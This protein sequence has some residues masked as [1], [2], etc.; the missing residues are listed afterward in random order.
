MTNLQVKLAK[1]TTKEE[2]ERYYSILREGVRK[3]A[4]S[5]ETC[6]MR[7]LFRLF[8]MD[9]YGVYRARYDT[10]TDYFDS[11][12]NSKYTNKNDGG[13]SRS[14]Y[15]RYMEAIKAYVEQYKL[16]VIEAVRRSTAIGATELLLESGKPP[17]EVL[18]ISKDFGRTSPQNAME[19]LRDAIGGEEVYF[20][21][22]PIDG[23]NP[24]WI[25][26][27]GNLG[28]GTLEFYLV[29]KDRN[30]GQ[31]GEPSV[32]TLVIESIAWREAKWLIADRPQHGHALDCLD[33][34]DMPF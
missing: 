14:N 13:M 22:N 1:V 4:R 10:Q 3:D 28:L 15:F 19:T 30:D 33:S 34:K 16:P 20:G 32:S 2:L 25:Q 5:E 11:E 17:E 23:A 8:L 27:E 24:R 29:T 9:Y 18:E 26:S 7:K 31:Y 21:N 6:F 12:V